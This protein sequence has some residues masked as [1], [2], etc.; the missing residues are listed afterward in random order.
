MHIYF[1]NYLQSSN[2]VK[3]IIKETYITSIKRKKNKS[4]IAV[5]VILQYYYNICITN[6]KSNT[7]FENYVIYMLQYKLIYIQEIKF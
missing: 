6:Y 4:F 3:S 1:I 7:I 5:Y 2:A